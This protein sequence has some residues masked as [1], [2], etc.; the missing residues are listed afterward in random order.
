MTEDLTGN[1]KNELLKT[2][3]K[4]EYLELI[5]DLIFVY[6]IGRNNSLLHAAEGGFVP[7]ELFIAYILCTLAIIQIWNYSTFYINMFGRN[8]VRDHVFLLVNMYLMYYIGE[9]TRLRW[10]NFHTQYHVAWA[11]VLINI[12]IQYLIELRS[13]GENAGIRQTIRYL[14]FVLFGEAALV[15][16]AI[17]TASIPFPVFTCAAIVFGIVMTC[18]FANKRKAELLDFGHLSERA[19]L[20]VVF[21]FGEMII[22]IASY[23]DGA[24]TLRSV[25][26]SLMGFLIVTALFLSYEM[27]YDH[28]IDREMK[29]TGMAYMMIHVFLIFAMNNMTTALEFMQD[30]KI[31]LLPKTIFLVSAFL[32]FYICL[33]SLM[34]FAKK[35]RMLRARSFLPPVIISAVFTAAMFL[36]KEQM[37]I[38]I[39][40]SVVYVFAMFAWF[41]IYRREIS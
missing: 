26:F 14:A 1:M 11:L 35:R 12:G 13:A 34:L 37:F 36:L 33:F 30:T 40:I 6:I 16:L 29:T 20:Y 39:A 10:E 19:M 21:T 25:Y 22:A 2:E 4:V 32:L 18:I 27:L 5:Y 38:N 17:P 7:A 8:G 9:G 28:I 23:F 24:L 15:L 3:K 41:Y 31:R